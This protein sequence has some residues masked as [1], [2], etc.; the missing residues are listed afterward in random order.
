MNGHLQTQPGLNK[1]ARPVLR[2]P[3]QV[4]ICGLQPGDDLSFAEHP[5]VT[6]VGIVFVPASRRYV[7]PQQALSMVSQVAGRASAVGVFVDAPPAELRSTAAYCGLQVLQL[8]GNETPDLCARLRSEGWQVWRS[9]AAGEVANPAHRTAL[10][11]LL[12]TFDGAVDAV[13]LDAAPPR[14]A[15]PG[16]NGGHGQRFDWTALPGLA[17]ALADAGIHIPIWVAGGITPENT[18]EL[19]S[20]FRPV[21]VDVSSG[22][23]TAGRKD[24][25]RITALIKAVSACNRLH[26]Q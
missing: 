21:G 11:Q 23:E 20:I 10:V 16:V 8:H 5:L 4:K 18:D 26:P 7:P 22:V 14:G 9:L 25:Q 24:P 12:R 19:L 3:V 6:H 15:A 1:E 17:A 13:L 2:A